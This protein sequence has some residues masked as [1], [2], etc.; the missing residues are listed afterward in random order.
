MFILEAWP[1]AGGLY[2]ADTGR[3]DRSCETDLG[4]AYDNSDANHLGGVASGGS[5]YG[6]CIGS[7]GRT[8]GVQLRTRVTPFD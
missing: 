1:N 6:I 8:D 3:R 7:W 5:S 4:C 2:D